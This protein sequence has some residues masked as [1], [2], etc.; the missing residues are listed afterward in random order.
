MI[1]TLIRG[2]FAIL[3]SLSLYYHAFITY[4]PILFALDMFIAS[5]LGIFGIW[6]IVE[7]LA[8]LIYTK[9]DKE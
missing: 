7:S 9:K 2:L 8:L 6:D 4:S 3:L 1:R 5:I